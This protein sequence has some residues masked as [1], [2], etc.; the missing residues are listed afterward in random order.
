MVRDAHYCKPFKRRPPLGG[1][2]L[3][4]NNGMFLLDNI[5]LAPAKSL[6]FIFRKIHEQVEGELQDTPEKL[7]KEL[8]DSQTL[9]DARQIS[10]DEYQRLEDSILARW[11]KLK[12]L[13]KNPH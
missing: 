9:L 6:M 13:N 8:Y 7:K 2:A 5:L 4:G 11:N 3:M 1:L 12:E 10:E